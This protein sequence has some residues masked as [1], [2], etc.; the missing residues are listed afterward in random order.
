MKSPSSKAVLIMSL[1]QQIEEIEQRL[2]LHHKSASLHA[3]A[4]NEKVRENLSSPI[5]LFI[6]AGIGFCWTY[7]ARKPEAKPAENVAE[8]S[9]ENIDDKSDKKSFDW[10]GNIMQIITLVEAIKMLIPAKTEPVSTTETSS[11]TGAKPETET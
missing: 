10:L 9:T 1:D 6:A 2:A 11:A 7:F 5:T 4:L 3:S 8:I